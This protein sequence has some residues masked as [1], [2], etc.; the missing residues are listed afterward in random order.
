MLLFTLCSVLHSGTYET[1]RKR[2]K[3]CAYVV[4]GF[5]QDDNFNGESSVVNVLRLTRIEGL[6]VSYDYSARSVSTGLTA[7]VR[8]AGR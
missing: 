5:S 8:R 4:F 6:H 2:R 7:A 1:G 3:Y